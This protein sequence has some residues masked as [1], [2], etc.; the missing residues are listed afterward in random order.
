MVIKEEIRLRKKGLMKYVRGTLGS[1]KRP[2]TRKSNKLAEK[3]S[4]IIAKHEFCN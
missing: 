4:P 2:S 1:N 3:S